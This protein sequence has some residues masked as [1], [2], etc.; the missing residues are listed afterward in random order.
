MGLI[1]M[2]PPED[3]ITKLS[4]EFTIKNFVETGTF[5]GT[6]AVYASE[7]FENVLTVERSEYFYNQARKKHKTIK[8]IKFIF[9]DSRT[10]LKKNY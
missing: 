9:G 2:G 8:N 10:E 4:S 3:L 6:T 5:E 7:H 1:R